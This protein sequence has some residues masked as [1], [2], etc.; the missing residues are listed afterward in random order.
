MPDLYPSSYSDRCPRTQLAEVDRVSALEQK[1]FTLAAQLQIETRKSGRSTAELQNQTLPVTVQLF[2]ANTV[3][4]HYIGGGTDWTTGQVHGQIDKLTHLSDTISAM[5]FSLTIPRVR[6]AG[7]SSG[8]R[9]Y[10][11]SGET[12]MA[13]NGTTNIE[14]IAFANER[15]A[16]IATTLS[17]VRSYGRGTQSATRGYVGGHWNPAG[18]PTVAVTP[19]PI[20]RMT[21]ATEAVSLLAVNLGLVSAGC[22]VTENSTAS[23]W[24]GG[25]GNTLQIQRL[26]FAA[27]TVAPITAQLSLKRVAASSNSSQLK[28]YYCMG[29]NLDSGTTAVTSV[30]AL[31][32]DTEAIATLGA[33]FRRFDADTTGASALRQGYHFYTGYPGAA[34]NFAAWAETLSYATETTNLLSA[35]LSRG[36]RYSCPVGK[37]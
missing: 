23:Y 34:G 37:I 35:L 30:D 24:A 5:D 16:T 19:G 11:A 20:E 6:H 9:G 3:G 2:P 1:L 29:V 4:R 25:Y 10:W 14:A 32:F 8:A 33:Q 15:R 36:G 26:N 13:F 31:R 21:F 22:A 12:N 18:T 27:E 7:F 17:A 28:G